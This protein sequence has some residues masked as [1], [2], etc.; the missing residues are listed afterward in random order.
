MTVETLTRAEFARELGYVD[1]NGNP[2]AR[3]IAQLLRDAMGRWGL[4]PRRA[5]LRHAREQ[6]RAGDVPVDRVPEVL[7]RLVALGECAEVAIGHELFIA[8][9]EPRWIAV[10][11]GSAV[12]L[13][14]LAVPAVLSP[15]AALPPDD[16]AV[17]VTLDSEEA[18]A[19]LDAVGWRQVSLEEWLHPPGFLRHVARRE[20]DAV[21]GDQWDLARFW[22]RLVSAIIEEGLLLGPDAELRAV[23]G[24]AGSFF[25]RHTAAGVEGR[26]GEQPPNGV[27]CAYRRGHGDDRW[28]PTLVSVDGDERRAL[29][30]FDDDEWR[31]ALLARSKAVGT[32]EVA[33]RAHGEVRVTW[34]L[35]AQFQAAMNII[36]VP[37]GPWRWQAAEDAPDLWSLLR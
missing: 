24:A 28:L 12:L 5:L 19:T 35:P 13:G 29:D 10:G 16:V 37:S 20:G 27:W 33:Q 18:A 4:S 26:W 17:R 3:A 1:L 36:G 15:V 22:E 6:L 34:P 14:T 7:E 32:A 30:L 31:W 8:P 2:S 11:G 9:A 21:R 23:V 25:G